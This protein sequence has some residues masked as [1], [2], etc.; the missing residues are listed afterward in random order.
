MSCIEQNYEIVYNEEEFGSM[1]R[2]MSFANMSRSGS[3]SS[4]FGQKSVAIRSNSH[5]LHELLSYVK[6]QIEYHLATHVQGNT[7][8]KGSSPTD[9]AAASASARERESLVG[10]YGVY[11]L[12]RQLLPRNVV[13]DT[14]VYK[15]LWGLYKQV[16]LYLFSLLGLSLSLL[17]RF[18]L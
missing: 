4:V 9:V 16:S 12:Y 17:C 3:M 10:V 2:G 5:F 18:R 14:K 7:P 13:P 11:V 8:E 6:S 15:V 1:S